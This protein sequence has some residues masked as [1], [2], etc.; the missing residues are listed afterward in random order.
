M[1]E[2]KAHHSGMTIH[3]HGDGTYHSHPPGM[4]HE[5]SMH[6]HH[7]HIGHALMHF[8]KHHSDGDHMHIHGHEDGFTTH[9]AHDGEAHG[10][11]H[12]KN[13]SEVKRHM[14]DCLDGE[15]EA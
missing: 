13:I 4:E 14:A 6:T 9:S 10:P 8:A 1:A 3:A 15:C 5:T 2:K 11:E 12:H 7:P